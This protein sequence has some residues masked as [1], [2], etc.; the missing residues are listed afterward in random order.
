MDRVI[1]PGPDGKPETVR[2]RILS[3]IALGCY[4]ETGAARA[5]V[6]NE[7]VRNWLRVGGRARKDLNDGRRTADDLTPHDVACLEFSVAVDQAEADGEAR[8][9]A[10]LER[11]SRGDRV[12]KRRTTTVTDPATG[13]V[14][15]TTTVEEVE[16]ADLATIRWRLERKAMSRWGRTAVEVTGPAGG[17]I[18]VSASDRA[19]GL[20]AALE[21]FRT[22]N[23]D[24]TPASNGHD[25]QEPR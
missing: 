12:T 9:V 13:T 4:L 17:P 11:A 6:T 15:S 16:G 25:H 14:T 10:E 7:T 19:D 22:A 5:G 2:E 21:A 1:G 8:L 18:E 20:A 23:P 24:P 3:T